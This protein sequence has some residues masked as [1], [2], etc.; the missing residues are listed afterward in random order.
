[1]YS[2]MRRGAP[3]AALRP[4][5]AEYETVREVCGAIV[6]RAVRTAAACTDS[7][8]AAAASTG[9]GGGSGAGSGAGA[10]AS[11]SASVSKAKAGT[12]SPPALKPARTR[13]GLSAWRM[14]AELSLKL[15]ASSVDEVLA[16]GSES[17]SGSNGSSSTSNRSNNSSSSG[18]RRP[19]PRV[20]VNIPGW[21]SY[22]GLFSGGGANV[23]VRHKCVTSVS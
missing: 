15:R 2:Y 5:F 23:M 1:M 4:W 18:R 10:S 22:P 13:R 20:S 21:V 9:S 17:G 7:A 19:Y 16:D 11:K 8:G 12:D 14:D 6:G 3:E